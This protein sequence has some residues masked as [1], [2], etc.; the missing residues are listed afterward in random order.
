M[1]Q[2]VKDDEMVNWLANQEPPFMMVSGD[3]GRKSKRGDP[4]MN[5]LCP[6]EGITSVFIAPKLC[7]EEG[8]EKVRMVMVCI[9]ELLEAYDG[10]RGV[11]YRLEAVGNRY[12]LRE[13]PLVTDLIFASGQPP[14]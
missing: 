13:W 4:R 7:Q 11:R 8:F 2:G 5:L 1:K 3:N 10:Q 14:S 12:R 9:P 6:Q